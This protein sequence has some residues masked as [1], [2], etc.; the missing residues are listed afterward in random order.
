MVGQWTD[1]SDSLVRQT[2]ASS[3]AGSFSG[4]SMKAMTAAHADVSPLL[5]LIA[6]SSSQRV[7]QDEK[8]GA[9]EL[10]TLQL[11]SD[12]QKATQGL[13]YNV[14]LYHMDASDRK[15]FIGVEQPSVGSS[16]DQVPSD[17]GPNMESGLRDWITSKYIPAWLTQRISTMG[18]MNKDAF[19]RQLTVKQRKRLR[20]WWEGKGKSCMSQDDHYNH[21]NAVAANYTLRRT[22]P[23]VN[24][25]LE[26]DNKGNTAKTKYK[27]ATTD[28]NG[29]KRWATALFNI[30][31]YGPG[32]S[33]LAQDAGNIMTTV[34]L[35]AIPS[36]F[37]SSCIKANTWAGTAGL[38]L[39]PENWQQ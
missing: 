39:T 1:G 38:Q 35:H 24:D 27:L 18:D 23:R 10:A 9:N 14:M 3:T 2:L 32:L 22:V 33:S 25:F 15:K 11:P 28:L 31:S 13:I 8:V 30:K 4:A 21:L 12:L 37:D 29:G 36:L 7:P 20:Y 19:R 26:D 6:F 5:S 17:L 34:G 16:A